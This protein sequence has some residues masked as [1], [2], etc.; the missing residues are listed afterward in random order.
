ME[1]PQGRARAAVAAAAAAALPQ[2]R[3]AEVGKV[4]ISSKYSCVSWHKQKKKFAAYI[5][6]SKPLKRKKKHLGL[7]QTEEAAARAYDKA[8]MDQ[9]LERR[10]NFP[11]ACTATKKI[12]PVSGT[13]A[14]SRH[15]GVHW[16]KKT[17]K[18]AAR[19]WYQKKTMFLGAF[20]L[21]DDAGRAYDDAVRKYFSDRKPMTWHRF[22][23]RD[24]VS[25]PAGTRQQQSKKSPAHKVS[26]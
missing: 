11:S 2:G 21:E 8:V 26:I 13:N 14:A 18:W 12:R 25:A 4:N 10:L 24:E 9:G 17:S 6:H 7:F 15:R 5:P 22:N 16:Q 23:F 19:I 1:L 20:K 3:A